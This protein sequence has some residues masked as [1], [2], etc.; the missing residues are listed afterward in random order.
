M[1]NIIKFLIVF[2]IRSQDNT[3]Y[4]SCNYNIVYFQK[5]KLKYKT[6]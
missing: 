5:E 6:K 2:V 3:L 4:N 1:P